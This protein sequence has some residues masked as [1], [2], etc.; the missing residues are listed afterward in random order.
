[1]RRVIPIHAHSEC[2]LAGADVN[3][4]VQAGRGAND[5]SALRDGKPQLI[6]TPHCRVGASLVGARQLSILALRP[7]Q[8]GPFRSFEIDINWASDVG[9]ASYSTAR[10]PVEV[11]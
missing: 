8:K 5:Q 1:M 7:V 6:I 11:Q 2:T 9:D 4:C 10:I 3:P